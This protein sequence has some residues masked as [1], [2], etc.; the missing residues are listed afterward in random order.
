[1]RICLRRL[2]ASKQRQH[3]TREHRVAG[4]KSDLCLRFDAQGGVTVTRSIDLVYLLVLYYVY[5]T[6]TATYLGND[7]VGLAMP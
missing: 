6:Q 1:M 3:Y 2:K 4:A 5:Y 7:Q